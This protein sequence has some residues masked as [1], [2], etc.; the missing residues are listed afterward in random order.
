MNDRFHLEEDFS[1]KGYNSINRLVY[2]KISGGNMKEIIILFISAILL[3]SCVSD[4]TEINKRDINTPN[5]NEGITSKII[6]LKK[7]KNA[8]AFDIYIKNST[9][10]DI[11]TVQQLGS[12]YNW[13]I[14]S[15]NI[16]IVRLAPI[17]QQDSGKGYKL[18]IPK[19]DIIKA[20]SEYNQHI[21]LILPY[22]FENPFVEMIDPSGAS[23]LENFINAKGLICYF[24][25]YY[26]TF[27]DPLTYEEY[28]KIYLQNGVDFYTEPALY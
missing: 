6:N 1:I 5:K 22:Y 19:F 21:K 2:Y 27:S 23:D 20:K 26:S 13:Q 7:D 16:A 11:C 10:N 4:T 14:R 24:K 18:I 8:I 17:L 12:G 15:D 9:N 25:I 28:R 3:S